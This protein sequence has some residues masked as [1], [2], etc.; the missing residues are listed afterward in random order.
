MNGASSS[1]L[2]SASARAGRPSSVRI[3]QKIVMKFAPS[4]AP[5]DGDWEAAYERTAPILRKTSVGRANLEGAFPDRLANEQALMRAGGGI[6]VTK[7]WSIDPR[8]IDA[9]L[10][11]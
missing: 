2:L 10:K 4:N 6:D 1:G 7:G 5:P 8:K 3:L 11:R 9:A